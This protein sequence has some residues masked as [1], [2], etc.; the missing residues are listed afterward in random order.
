MLE[1]CYSSCVK[2]VRAEQEVEQ[3]ECYYRSKSAEE[4]THRNTFFPILL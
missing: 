3:V 2:I 1:Y 4:S